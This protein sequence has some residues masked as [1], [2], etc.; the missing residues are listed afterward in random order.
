VPD[1]PPPAYP[2]PPPLAPGYPAKLLAPPAPPPPPNEIIL[3][4]TEGAPFAEGYAGC[5]ASDI[6]DPAPPAPT[7][8]I[9][10]ADESVIVNDPILYPPAPPPPAGSVTPL[11]PAPPPPTT[12]YC[13]LGGGITFTVTESEYLIVLGCPPILYAIIAHLK[14]FPISELIGL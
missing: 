12:K 13:T 7:V 2:P 6:Y 10:F 4:K 5:E 8:T 9:I 14:F 11:P 1:P 3:E